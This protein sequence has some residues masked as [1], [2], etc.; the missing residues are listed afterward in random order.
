ME[1][2]KLSFGGGGGGAGLIAHTHNPAIP[3]DGG[4]LS[5]SSPTTVSELPILI[6]T[7]IYG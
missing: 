1:N 2:I 3:S 4:Q 6:H 7:V 5:T